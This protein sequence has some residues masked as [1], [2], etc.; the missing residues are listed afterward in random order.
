MFKGKGVVQITGRNASKSVWTTKAINRLMEE[1][2]ARPLED[3]KLSEGTVYGARYYCAEPIGGHWREMET[4]CHRTFG[5]SS[6]SPI[7]GEA[8]AVN[9]G[10]RWYMNNRKFWFRDEKDR[11]M[12]ILRWS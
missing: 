7:W 10:E 6:T 9:P 1:L 3:I 5:E 2:A 8:K 12:F 11:T 4:W